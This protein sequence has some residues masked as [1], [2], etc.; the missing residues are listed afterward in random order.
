MKI[1]QLAEGVPE[2]VRRDIWSSW[3][4]ELTFFFTNRTDLLCNLNS[5]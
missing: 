1:G 2:S 4:L 3:F 5:S